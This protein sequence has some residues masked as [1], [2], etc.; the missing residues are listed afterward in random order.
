MPRYEAIN[1]SQTGNGWGGL[2]YNTNGECLLD[3]SVSTPQDW[4]Y[5]VGYN[6]GN[7]GQGLA[8]PSYSRPAQAV[9]L[10]AMNPKTQ[11]WQVCA[12]VGWVGGWMGGCERW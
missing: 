1:V 11:K 4:F 6:G 2:R 3:G 12:C 5:C 8:I 7:W 9:E 10:F